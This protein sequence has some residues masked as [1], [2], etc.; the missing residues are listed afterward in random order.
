MNKCFFIGNLT[1]A[2]EIRATS[3]GTSQCTFSIAV[4]RRNGDQA[5]FIR[6]IT[7]G[8]QAENCHQYL[9]KGRKVAITGELHIDSYEKDGQKR[10][11]VTVMANEVEFLSPKDPKP[12]VEQ[13]SILDEMKDYNGD[14]PF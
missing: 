11:T 13:E 12:K 7:F 14:L 10:S 1:A 2:P 3:K 4:K 6:V 5:D 9:D 8:Q